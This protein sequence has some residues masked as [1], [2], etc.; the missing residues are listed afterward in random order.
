MYRR[1]I[2]NDFVKSRTVSIITLLFIT[3]AAM[4]ISLAVML[5]VELSGAI[6]TLMAQART[7]HFLQMHSGELHTV[8]L[9]RFAQ[10]NKDV[11]EFQVL[12]FLN[13]DGSEI[14]IGG[15]SL[16]NSVQDNGLCTQGKAFD[17]L[18]DLDGRII[19]PSEGELY[20]P[21]AYGKDGTA[22]LG[23]KAVI[24]GRELTVAGFLRDSQM[25]SLL[26]SSKRFLVS[27]KDYAAIRNSGSVEYLIEFRLKDLSALGAFETA[28]IG[29]GLEANG[30][31]VTYPLFRMINAVSDGLMIAVLLLISVL[32]V[33]IAFL[34]IRF[35][36]L[37]KIEEDTREIG[38]MKAIGLRTS[39]I[40][41]LYLGKYAAVAAAGSTLGWGCSFVFEGAVLENIRL[42]M[43][44]GDSAAS[45]RIF[46]IAAVLLIFFAVTAYVNTMLNR[47]RKISPAQAIRLGF[48]SGAGGSAKGFPLSKNRRLDTNVFLGIKEVLSRKGLYVTMLMVM[49]AST[50]IVLVPQNL[51]NTIS[52]PGFSTYMGIGGCDI[53]IGIQQTEHI[54]E[55]TAEI[56]HT[57]ENDGD[58][59][60]YAVLTTKR[61]T[62]RSENG[63]EEQIKVELGNHTVFPVHYV[64]GSAPETENEIALSAINADELG[65]QIGDTLVL[66][67]KDWEK[68]LTVCGIYSDI[69]NGGKTAKAAFK[70]NSGSV[71]WH[72][73]C[74]EF[75][76]NVPVGGKAAKYTGQFPFAKVADIDGYIAQTFGP[77][78]RS[79][80]SVSAAGIL[81]AL[82]MT[83]LITLMMMKMLISK[84]R[85]SIAVMKALGFTNKD[86]TA[87]YLSRFLLV[88]FTG[89]LAGTFFA[90]TLGEALAGAVIA[91][92]G[93]TSFQFVINPL[94]A[95][96]FFPLAMGCSVLLAVL[97]STLGIRKIQVS[98]HIKE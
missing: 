69:T 92:F 23:D 37:A 93:A 65:K 34:C 1:I 26:A 22:Q 97:L 67:S 10:G 18:L 70:E 81:V 38:V 39:D 71:M 60:K 2:W 80:G 25:N 20:V 82:L 14:I 55:K 63:A 40:K 50:F 98:E 78:I 33:L 6:D 87:Q 7:P 79:I 29:G 42:S 96:L 5:T 66:V 49:M 16:A 62:I 17:Y 59:A 4:L 43:G 41:R 88:L 35:S 76:Q 46:G 12:E 31:T 28:Y 48:V 85:H 24:A 8:R 21:I 86:I 56:S 68:V 64:R 11:E 54:D 72:T 27:E 90:N 83:I 47:F 58:V 91:S 52:S 74:V 45:T 51:Y 75:L 57:L 61:F 36:L 73:V 15:K 30:P 13:M 95:Y 44:A 94:S 89:I 32:A 19:R 84:E 53:L 77:T 3:A 9:E